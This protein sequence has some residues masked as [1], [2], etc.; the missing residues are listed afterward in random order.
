ME[1]RDPVGGF[2]GDIYSTLKE[3]ISSPFISSFAIAWSAI[4]YKI[5]V[6]LFSDKEYEAKIKLI[7]EMFDSPD[8]IGLF[9]IMFPL[10]VAGFYVYAWPLLSIKINWYVLD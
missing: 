2:L 7:D 3:R 4:N 6:L 5:F 9:I 8:E 10:I 1:S